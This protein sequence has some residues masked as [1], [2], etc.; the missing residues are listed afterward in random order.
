MRKERCLC[1]VADLRTLPRGLFLCLTCG[2]IYRIGGEGRDT[3]RINRKKF[4]PVVDGSPCPS[5]LCDG[6][7]TICQDRRIKWVECDRCREHIIVG[8]VSQ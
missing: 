5:E 4:R 6:K 3:A 2:A 8:G 7:L 1:P